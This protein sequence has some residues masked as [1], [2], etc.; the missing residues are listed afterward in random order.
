MHVRKAAMA[1]LLRLLL[2][3]LFRAMRNQYASAEKTMCRRRRKGYQAWP[4]LV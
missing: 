1:A 3:I 2:S 4:T